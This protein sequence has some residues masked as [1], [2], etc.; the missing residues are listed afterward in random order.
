[1]RKFHHL[2][3]N[4][5]MSRYIKLVINKTSNYFLSINVHSFEHQTIPHLLIKPS[6]F[7]MLDIVRCT[8]NTLSPNGQSAIWW[9]G[10]I[11]VFSVGPLIW[12]TQENH[13]Q[14][15]SL[16]KPCSFF[17]TQAT[18]T[19]TQRH[20]GYVA[21]FPGND[22]CHVHRAMTMAIVLSKRR[23]L[24]NNHLS[25]RLS[26]IAHIQ[27]QKGPQ[28]LSTVRRTPLPILHVEQRTVASHLWY[29]VSASPLSLSVRT[30]SCGHPIVCSD[31]EPWSTEEKQWESHHNGAFKEQQDG[32]MSTVYF[33]CSSEAQR[34][35]AAD[36]TYVEMRVDAQETALC[37]D[38]NL[39]REKKIIIINTVSYHFWT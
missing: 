32:A 19:Q 23:S 2:L 33:D 7:Y 6:I 1:M 22:S 39:Y 9:P 36:H 17:H 29:M 21:F 28:M 34:D 4:I 20:Q 38:G 8:W 37:A 12:K 18:C 13:T 30:S 14:W 24:N 3:A 35:S 15:F 5:C 11:G 10:G 31:L 16:A 26:A 27:P 25:L